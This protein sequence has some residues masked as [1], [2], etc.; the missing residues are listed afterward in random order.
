MESLEEERVE[1][2]ATSPVDL[3]ATVADNELAGRSSEYLIYHDKG[4]KELFQDEKLH[5]F[6]FLHLTGTVNFV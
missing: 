6:G 2:I 5:S 3:K 4:W 1:V